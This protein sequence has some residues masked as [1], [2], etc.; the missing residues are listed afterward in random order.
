MFLP[1]LH[2]MCCPQQLRVP[3]AEVFGPLFLG[4]GTGGGQG[5][6]FALRHGVGALPGTGNQTLCSALFCVPQ[7]RSMMRRWLT[8]DSSTNSRGE[9]SSSSIWSTEVNC[10]GPISTGISPNGT[11]NPR[12]V[13]EKVPQRHLI[14]CSGGSRSRHLTGVSRL[15]S[16]VRFA[17]T[18]KRDIILMCRG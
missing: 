1:A 3:W 5:V 6:V 12:R 13:Q 8:L 15:L 11:V 7:V 16:K 14:P 2:C 17:D 18:S 9:P 10:H 4:A